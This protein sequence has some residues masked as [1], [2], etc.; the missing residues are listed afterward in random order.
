M[1]TFKHFSLEEREK[2]FTWD[3]QGIAL[4]EIGRRLGRSHSSIKREL[5]RNRTGIGRRSNEYLIFRYLPCK[6]HEKARKRAA[7]QR[8]K[9]PLK[10]PLIFLYVREH[11]RD[12]YRWT[13]EQIAGRLPIDHDGKQITTETIYAYI[14]GKGKQF[15]LWQYLPLARKKRMKK[16]GRSV[17]RE[18]KIPNAVSI[19]LRPKAVHERKEAGHWETDDIEGKRSDRSVVSATIERLTLLLLLSKMKDRSA[20]AKTDVVTERL[21]PFP[22]HVRR[23]MTGD[24]GPENSNHEEITEA[25][26]MPMYFCHAYHSWEKPVVENM[27][28]RVRRYIPKGIRIDHLSEKKLAEIEHRLNST[29]RKRLGFLT[30]YEKMEQMLAQGEKQ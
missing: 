15:K 17:H 30:P 28:G 10:E 4:R 3:H 22:E 18:S 9:A 24:N 21:M 5:K 25:L 6:A 12:P 8:Q 13:P 27:I 1:R 23:T 2:L 11:V 29:P 14:Y 20:K 26:T 16:N 19:D 7:R